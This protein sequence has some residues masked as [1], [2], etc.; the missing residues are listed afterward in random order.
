[1]AVSAVSFSQVNFTYQ[2]GTPF[3]AQAL[4]NLN[5]TIEEGSYTAV[6]GRTG[7]GKSTIMQ[8]IDG[9]LK[10]TSGVI[11]VGSETAG[12]HASR[13]QLAALRQKTGF[14]FQFP[15]SQLFADTVIDD[16]MFGPRNLGQGEATAQENAV[17][18]LQLVGIDERYYQ[19]SPFDLSG[20]QMRRV[21]IAG[22][23]AM[24]PS[25]L[26]L[27]EPTAGLDSQGTRQ[28]LALIARLHDEGTTILLVTHQMDQVAAYAD[29]VL[30]MNAG[31]VAFQGSPRALF[32]NQQLLDQNSLR[33]PETVA[34]ARALAA[35]GV[36]LPQPAALT[37]DEL[38]DQLA[39]QLKGSEQD[40]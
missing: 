10:P 19:R 12:P 18:A 37:I 5:F 21:A 3:A 9:L 29:T 1:M 6:I 34:F 30:V 27:D 11:Q 22:V 17:G 38:A 26:I 32:A 35:G 40:G 13:R 20:G 4:F 15:E 16:V 8:L 28:M 7:S 31:R 14:V 36:Q 24:K 25:L 23:L 39:G 33:W 2:A